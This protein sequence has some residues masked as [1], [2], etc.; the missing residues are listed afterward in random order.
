ME[1][2]NKREKPFIFSALFTLDI[3]NISSDDEL[4]QGKLGDNRNYVNLLLLWGNNV[5][6]NKSETN[7]SRM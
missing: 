5:G 3:L 4:S 2:K 7:L 1:C 6:N